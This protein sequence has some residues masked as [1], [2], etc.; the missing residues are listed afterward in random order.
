MNA[1][2]AATDPDWVHFLAPQSGIDEVNFWYPKPW[3]GEFGDGA[4]SPA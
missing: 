2:V 3:G 1:Y 4:T